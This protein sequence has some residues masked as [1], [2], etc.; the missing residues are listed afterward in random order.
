[1]SLSPDAFCRHHCVSDGGGGVLTSGSA[2]TEVVRA[3]ER[4]ADIELRDLAREWAERLETVDEHVHVPVA[5]LE[6]AVREQQRLPSHQ[7]AGALVY[8]RR[9]EEGSRAGVRPD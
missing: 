4:L 1:M 8:R 5:P 9:G 6:A 3:R 2:V 7:R